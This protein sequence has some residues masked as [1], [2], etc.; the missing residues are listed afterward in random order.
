MNPL[1]FVHHENR[2]I[3][4]LVVIFSKMKQKLY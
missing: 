4:L 2:R 3:Q 1:I